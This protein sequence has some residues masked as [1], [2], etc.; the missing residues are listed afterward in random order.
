MRLAH[1][2]HAP[3]G[4]GEGAVLLGEGRRGQEDVGQLGRLVHEEVLD[5]QAVELV[6][7]AFAT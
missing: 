4:V 6:R 7:D 5:D 2:L 1:A 3:L